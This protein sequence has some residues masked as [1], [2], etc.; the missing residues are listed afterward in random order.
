MELCSYPK[1]IECSLETE[2]KQGDRKP[3]PMAGK[4]SQRI[5]ASEF[6]PSTR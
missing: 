4:M 1:G 2:A 5:K 6:G 3:Q